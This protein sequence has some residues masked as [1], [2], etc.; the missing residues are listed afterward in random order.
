MYASGIPRECAE[1]VPAQ[2]VPPPETMVRGDG[3][4]VIRTVRT[5]EVVEYVD[6]DVRVYRVSQE[7]ANELERLVRVSEVRS[8]TAVVATI[9]AA[10]S[11]SLMASLIP[12][13]HLLQVSALFGVSLCII[14]VGAIV[15]SKV[16]VSGQR[17]VAAWYNEHGIPRGT[18]VYYGQDSV[19]KAD[20]VIVVT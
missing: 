6:H 20:H 19:M 5:R 11:G 15:S 7:D 16:L 1:D 12:A 18:R 9:V 4:E 2:R 17:A 14:V 3:I 10:V 13:A 8:V